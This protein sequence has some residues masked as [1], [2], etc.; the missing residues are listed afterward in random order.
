MNEQPHP[1]KRLNVPMLIV[2]LVVGVIF[3]GSTRVVLQRLGDV[4]NISKG[5][6][7]CRQITMALKLY[8]EDHG[9]KLPDAAL[10]QPASSNE[11]FRVLFTEYVLD[12]EMMFDCPFSPFRT[13]GNLGPEPGFTK[14]LEAGENHWAM[15][16][17][18]GKDT[19]GSVPLVYENPETA[20]WPPTWNFR[21]RHTLTKGRTWP[22][23]VI[24][25]LND[26]SATLQKVDAWWWSG[27]VGLAKTSNGKDIF[28]AAIDP[29]KF[30]QGKVLD[31]LQKGK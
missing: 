4:G 10:S 25:G 18:I 9:G 16:A 6:S 3:V 30:P 29:V 19:P 14:A 12:H 27:T 2:I 1:R 15:T 8:A 31:V 26:G 17:G 24:I 13:D 7:N 22:R 21:A 28:E 11:V 5:I 23:G 20:T